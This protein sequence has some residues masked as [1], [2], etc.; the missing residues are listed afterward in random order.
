M[1]QNRI[2]LC[3]IDSQEGAPYFKFRTETGA[4]HCFW[5]GVGQTHPKNLDR[6]RKNPKTTS[7]NHDNHK[8]QSITCI[9]FTVN[10]LP[11]N[12]IFDMLPK[13]TGEGSTLILLFYAHLKKKCLLREKVWGGVPK[14]I[15]KSYHKLINWVNLCAIYKL[16]FVFT[17]FIKKT[18]T[19]QHIM[20]TFSIYADLFAQFI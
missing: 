20:T 8:G 7:Q 2:C 13:K 15:S 6:Q 12:S 10:F 19:Q 14:L 16:L 9:I 17:R 3:D 5:K 4:W 11:F 18:T 1:K